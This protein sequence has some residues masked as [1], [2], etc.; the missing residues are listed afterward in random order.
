MPVT[1]AQ[2][3]GIAGSGPFVMNTRQELEKA[4]ADFHSGRM[5]VIPQPEKELS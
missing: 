1:A 4:Y 3:T 2:A 5:G